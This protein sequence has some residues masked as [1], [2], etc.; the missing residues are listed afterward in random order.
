[1]GAPAI[2]E[3]AQ[4]GGGG[5]WRRFYDWSRAVIKINSGTRVA[6]V[7]AEGGCPT[8]KEGVRWRC[9]GLMRSAGTQTP[10]WT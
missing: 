2:P 4:E 5:I 8:Q 1:M 10:V 3:Q 9:S 6:K 7:E